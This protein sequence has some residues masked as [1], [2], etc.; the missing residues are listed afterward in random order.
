M[1]SRLDAEGLSV[2]LARLYQDLEAQLAEGVAKRLAKGIDSPDWLGSKLAA[3]GEVRRWAD[4][5]VKRVAGRAAPAVKR[6]VEAAF[7]RGG[8]AAQRELAGRARRRPQLGKV[9]SA[10]PGAQS[11]DRLASSLAG[12]LDATQP[13]VVRS[14]V[15][16]YREVVTA[17]AAGMLGGV[18][19]R[20]E[21]SQRVWNRLLDRGFTG[22]TDVKG[23]NW[24]LAGY[25][26]MATR[27]TTAQAAV[28]GQLDRQAQLGLD[29]VIV[30]NAP[31]ECVRCRPWEGKILT[32]DESGR[33]GRTLE[34]EHATEDKTIKVHV[35]GSVS[36][37]L[38]DG[39]L[40]PNCRHSLSAY[41]PG[42]TVAPTHTA[43]P[44]GDKARQKLRALER[45]VRSAKLQQQGALTEQGKAQAVARAR[46]AQ[47]KIRAHV[48]DNEHLGI[49][50]KP[51]R[52]APHLGNVR[53][54]PLEQAKMLDDYAAGVE[55][56]Q[57]LGGGVMARTDL[58]TTRGGRQLVRKRSLGYTGRAAKVEQDAEELGAIVVRAIGG[59][60]PT[61]A[62]L[63]DD[64]VLME[65]IPGR[66]LDE[67]T[68]A[69][70]LELARTP[71]ARRIGLADVLMGNVDRNKGNV[72]L[73]DDGELHAIDHGSA[74][75][76]HPT[77]NSPDRIERFR[78][79]YENFLAPGEDDQQDDQQPPLTLEEVRALQ[80]QLGVLA[81][82]FERRGHKSWF[83]AMSRRLRV[84]SGLARR[85][86]E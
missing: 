5:L 21:A 8:D 50:R 81:D 49:K 33:G 86:E 20:R 30:S 73:G 48:S 11:I 23:R 16:A 77:H 42:I 14:V 22:F 70:Q 19:T 38:A 62:R 61:V 84:L 6:A 54:P 3:A 68:A 24:S 44:E 27:T 67:L 40:H 35:A 7:K 31:Q 76:F 39:L 55:H 59:R 53:T 37:A 72:I 75:D 60:A 80:D 4:G 82:E 52:E 34:V 69:E 10:L 66:V 15:D 9:R 1:V 51:E 32:R 78:N 79:V 26:E 83:D 74:F 41:L 25:V 45:E 56:E 18:E 71:A 17:G 28:A 29:L 47:A 2:E 65:H 13:R 58:V 63:S 46:A 36:E 57:R 64:V 12:R 43:D 85:A